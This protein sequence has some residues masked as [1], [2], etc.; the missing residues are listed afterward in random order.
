[1][2]W[3]ERVNHRDRRHT[4]SDLLLQVLPQHLDLHLF[5]KG[6][7]VESF[8]DRGC[9]S[10]L[11]VDGA[12][13]RVDSRLQDNPSLSPT[14][15][16]AIDPPSAHMEGT[17]LQVQLSLDLFQLHPAFPY[18]LIAGIQPLAEVCS[19]AGTPAIP[20][21]PRPAKH[22]VHLISHMVDRGPCQPSD[23]PRSPC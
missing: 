6:V 10:G 4:R 7:L 5:G 11:R 22:A 17:P 3:S 20:A 18:L 8:M 1:V 2:R 15:M 12:L 16:P 13:I 23:R 14:A 9:V 21:I 19:M